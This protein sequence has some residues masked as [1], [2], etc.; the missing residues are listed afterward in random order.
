MSGNVLTAQ[1]VFTTLALLGV[2]QKPVTILFANGLRDLFQATTTLERI[3]SFLLEDGTG[4]VRS[5]TEANHLFHSELHSNNIQL[6]SHNQELGNQLS[7]KVEQSP[8]TSHVC[9]QGKP[10]L[11]LKNVQLHPYDESSSLNL[12]L[13]SSRLIGITGPVGCGKTSLFHNIIGEIPSTIG[14]ISHQGRIAYV[15]QTPWVFSGTI[16]E[17]ILFGKEYKSEALQRAIDVC[18]LKEDLASLPSGDMTH[19]GERGVSLSG[20]QRARVNLARAVYSDADIYLMDDPLSAVDAKVSNELFERL[21][22]GALSDRIRLF[23]THQ[24]YCLQKTDSILLMDKDGAVSEGSFKELCESGYFSESS[25]ITSPETAPKISIASPLEAYEKEC[26]TDTRNSSGFEIEEEDRLTGSVSYLS[27]WKYF[28]SGMS[29]LFMVV[30]AI[31]IL[32]P[33]GNFFYFDIGFYY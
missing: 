27:Y 8:L 14:N 24:S 29:K 31:L 28:R 33:E 6:N 16:R 26:V 15:C 21:I 22:T 11:C 2:L 10:F 19:V 25:L 3:E 18:S 20:G 9:N 12:C 5:F 17:N 32:L 30:M 13:S 7:C 1:N 4:E 23:I